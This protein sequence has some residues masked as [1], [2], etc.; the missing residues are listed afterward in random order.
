MVSAT[1][2]DIMDAENHGLDVTVVKGKGLKLFW[3]NR[4]V[5]TKSC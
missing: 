5:R 2:Y 4:N 1:P 3:Y